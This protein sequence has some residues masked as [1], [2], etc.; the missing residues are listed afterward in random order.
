VQ[1][2]DSTPDCVVKRDL[3]FGTAVF[4]IIAR[5]QCFGAELT[6][7]PVLARR[8]VYGLFL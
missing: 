2:G 3:L 8:I 6:V 7:R 1:I 5:F 4:D